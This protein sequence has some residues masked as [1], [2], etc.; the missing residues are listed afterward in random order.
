MQKSGLFRKI[1][2]QRE[3]AKVNRAAVRIGS[4]A[5]RP[6]KWCA[7][8][9]AA[10][11]LLGVM[12]SSA[13]GRGGGGCLEKGSSVLTPSGPVAVED[14]K[15]GDAVLSF[16]D[17]RVLAA[18][19]QAASAVDADAYCE[20]AVGGHVL[21]LTGEHP[22]A[23]APGVFRIV[24]S[25]RPGD[26]VL[27]GGRDA[28]ADGVV[29][30][31]KRLPAK[32]FAYNLLVSPGGTYLAN[33]IVVHNKGCFLP[34]TLVRKEDGSE[35]PISSVRP[36][37]RLLAFTTRGEAVIAR[38]RTVVTCEAD[39]YRIVTTRNIA[40]RVTAEHPFYVGNGAFK[41]LEALKVGDRIFAFD[42][43]GLSAAPIESIA[44][45]HKKVL[46]YNLQ[47]DAPNTF[48]ANG[49]LVHN[50]GGG[51]GGGGFGGGGYHGGGFGG[52]GYH[53]GS[54]TS[55]DSSWI[56]PTVFLAC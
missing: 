28:V 15:P 32:G 4:P 42:G 35:V 55:S 25:L 48:L 10:V 30:S 17:G 27:I 7:I 26:R 34:E 21:R 2:D 6:M 9:A 46:V 20:I 3:R 38:V 18:K 12:P 43:R 36:K 23:T 5:R 14:L 31:V 56:G 51:G 24:S 22:V 13:P 52:G 33:G 44:A 50:K 45:V 29:A 39:Q 19:V 11:F 53:G 54:G 1:S 8:V 41:T 16:S 37:D 40:V 49:L 47:T